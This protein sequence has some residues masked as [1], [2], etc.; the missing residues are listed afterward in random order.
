[1]L[2]SCSG[3]SAVVALT[4]DNHLAISGDGNELMKIWS[5]GSGE[6]VKT[7]NH[8]DHIT[9]LTITKDSQFTITG[10]KD[11]SLKVWETKTGRLSQVSLV[12]CK[13]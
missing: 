8:M 10:S 5:V 11:E 1:M 2:L 3:P 12:V 9:C 13:K 7:I 6:S 4:P